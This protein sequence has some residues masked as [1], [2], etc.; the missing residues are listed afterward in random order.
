[1]K[2]YRLRAMMGR[3]NRRSAH[4]RYEHRRT[5]GGG[6]RASRAWACSACLPYRIRTRG[7]VVRI[8]P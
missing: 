6:M 3:K 4:N 8:S 7:K 1:M 5:W 2:R